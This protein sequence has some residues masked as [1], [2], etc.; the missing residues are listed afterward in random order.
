MRRTL[1][2]VL[3]LSAGGCVS[4]GPDP[5]LVDIQ[6]R[7]QKTEVLLQGEKKA[8]EKLARQVSSLLE[9]VR[10]LREEL[11]REGTRAASREAERKKQWSLGWSRLEGR[12]ASLEESTTKILQALALRV[13]TAL[14]G[15]ARLEKGLGDLQRSRE[16]TARGLRENTKA[17]QAVQAGTAALE[18][19]L[20]SLEEGAAR[21][22]EERAGILARLE[23]Q[24]KLLSGLPSKFPK[25][26]NQKL[27]S[28]ISRI[29]SRLALL[30]NSVKELRRLWEADVR[31]VLSELKDS[32]RFGRG[33]TAALARRLEE[34]EKK[35]RAAPWKKEPGRVEG[36]ASLPASKP[37][38]ILAA[39]SR[40]VPSRRAGAL[41]A[42]LA[43]GGEGENP[44]DP[45]TGLGARTWP[46]L[47][48]MGAFLFLLLVWALKGNASQAEEGERFPEA[49]VGGPGG[50]P[51][52]EGGEAALPP[53]GS[54]V[55]PSSR[56]QAVIPASR[57]S[58]PAGDLPPT[59]VMAELAP[60]REGAGAE[61]R[62]REALRILESSPL[63]LAD[64]EIQVEPD[65][66]TGKTRIFF[67]VPGFATPEEIRE[68]ASRV[69]S[70]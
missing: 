51:G 2:L 39:R 11:D 43:A 62:V 40:P 37:S 14:D 48:G 33:E 69:E 19:S 53:R 42:P 66:E 20:S 46:W 64:P 9:T 8:R 18:K 5:F 45:A 58:G 28:R 60:G 16:E 31:G 26:E 54:A 70:L 30:E 4:S 15:L 52:A 25:P 67:W 65:K 44:W 38:G 12:L 3:L 50:G 55:R 47:L 34:L 32:L 56:G 41:P 59:R 29:E 21:A 49:E 10:S 23:K 22:A 57:T 35:V 13:Q 36:P 7:T 24:G 6:E 27:F 68:L 17:L 63:C 1:S 61:E